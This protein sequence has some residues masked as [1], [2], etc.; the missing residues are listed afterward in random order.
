VRATSFA[1][2]IVQCAALGLAIAGLSRIQT[3]A[4]GDRETRFVAAELAANVTTETESAEVLQASTSELSWSTDAARDGLF[5]W[6]ETRTDKSWTVDYRMR[7][8]FSSHTCYEFGTPP[9]QSPT[10]APLSRLDWSLD[11][12]WHGLQIARKTTD[13]E[14]QFEWLAPMRRRIDGV[15]ADYDWLTDTQPDHLDSLSASALRWNDGQMLDLGG[16]FHLCDCIVLGLPMEVW[17]MAGFR[18]QRF[19]MTGHDGIQII[20]D[21]PSVPPPGTLLPGDLITFKQQYYIGYIGGQLRST[22]NVPNLPPVAMTFQG[23]WGATAGYNVDHHLFYEQF[24]VHRYT[25]E[26]THGGSMHLSLAGETALSKRISLGLQFDHTEIRTKGTHT[27]LTYDDFGDRQRSS[28]GNG[29]KVVS[30]QNALTLFLRAS[31]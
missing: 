9:T 20:G 13:W 25:M 30:D 27:W 8:L 18:F 6:P 5:G 4:A 17:P 7:W 29:V 3:A 16:S 28:W 11:S 19:A 31:F 21:D 24:G 15:I 22:L 2:A 26:A 23:D 14:V 12:P 1:Q 10:Y